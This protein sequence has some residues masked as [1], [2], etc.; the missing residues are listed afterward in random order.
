MSSRSTLTMISLCGLALLAS[1]AAAQ[2]AKKQPVSPEVIREGSGARRDSLTAKELEPFDATAWSKVT[3]WAGA[4]PAAAD[5]SGQVVLICTWKYYHPV[6]KR[7]ME[8]A[9]KLSEQY[10]GKGLVV[11]A[12]HDSQNWD[13]AQK[14]AGP[15]PANKDAKFFVGYDEKGD[16]RKAIESDGDPDFYLID[17]AGQLRYADIGTES[18]E[19]TVGKL[20]AETAEFASGIKAAFAKSAE[21]LAREAAKSTDARGAMDMSSIPA[22][23]PGFTAPGA[24]VFQAIHWPATIYQTFGENSSSSSDKEKVAPVIQLPD[25]EGWIGG[26]PELQGR[27]WVVYFWSLD[28]YESYQIMQQMDQLQKARGRDVAVVGVLTQLKKD[29]SSSEQKPEDPAKLLK[30]VADFTRGKSLQHSTLVEPTGQLVEATRGGETSNVIP[31]PYAVVCSSDG[32]VRFAGW[33]KH[34]S[35]DSTLE[36]TLAMDPGVRARRAADAAYLKSKSK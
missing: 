36:N 14:A 32:T 24:D 22:I 27:V 16:F 3:K 13:E 15:A 23:P 1:P 6:S 29:T 8:L 25:G 11:V 18:V 2:P 5:M 17:R 9:R 26:K 35:F 4:A 19:P 12:V 20:L 34:P 21:Q 7:A 31:V 30:K 33:A 10:A 28:W